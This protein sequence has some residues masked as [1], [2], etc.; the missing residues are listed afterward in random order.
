MNKLVICRVVTIKHKLPSQLKRIR[1][2]I[3]SYVKCKQIKASLTSPLSGVDQKP[4]EYQ[5][6]GLTD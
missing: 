6:T 3:R 1:A 4:V 2:V 5:H